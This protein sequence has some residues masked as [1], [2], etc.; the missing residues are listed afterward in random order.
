MFFYIF[1]HFFLFLLGNY[2]SRWIQPLYAIL[3]SYT[4]QPNNA[5]GLLSKMLNV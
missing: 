4:S 1:Y 2:V 3:E 5:L